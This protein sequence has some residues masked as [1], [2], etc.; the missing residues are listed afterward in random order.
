MP[1]EEVFRKF[2]KG[3][4][5]SGSGHKVTDRDQAIA[6]AL[7]YDRKK[8]SKSGEKDPKRRAAVSAAL[9]SK[10]TSGRRKT[11]FDKL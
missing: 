2:K 9:A 4:L 7:S 1:K 6:I 11:A 10:S 5:K 8:S 3:T